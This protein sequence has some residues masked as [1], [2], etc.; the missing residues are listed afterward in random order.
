MSSSLVAPGLDVLLV[1]VAS[2][3]Y[4]QVEAMVKICRSFVMTHFDV[5]WHTI[6]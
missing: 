2:F 5:F 6:C 1:L 4:D 3:I